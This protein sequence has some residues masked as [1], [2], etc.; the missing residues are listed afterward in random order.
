MFKRGMIIVSL[1]PILLG[2]STLSGLKTDMSHGFSRFTHKPACC[3]PNTTTITYHTPKFTKIKA[4][5]TMNLRVQ[6]HS[7]GTWVRLHGDSRDLCHVRWSVKHN[8]LTIYS[9]QSDQHAPVDVIVNT[10][11]LSS[12]SFDGQ[13][14][15]TAKHLRSKQLDLHIHN[16]GFSTLEG[17]MNLHHVGLSGSGRVEIKSRNN[18]AMSLFLSGRVQTKIVGL[19]N[20][21]RLYMSG[22]SY[23]SLYWIKSQTLE[24]TMTDNARAQMAG[25]ANLAYINMDKNSNLNARYLRATEAFVKTHDAALAKI[26]VVTT[27]HTL[28]KDQSNIYYFNP[29]TYETD[30]MAKNGAVLDLIP[31]DNES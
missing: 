21:K 2:C 17:N 1:L 9:K 25:M 13:G 30:F 31:E 27:Q 14:T 29:A 11:Q 20:L 4:S 12:L 19:T 23:A 8:I 26:A 28:A 24:V 5:G 7:R 22:K 15:L 10:P 6:T 16:K 18:H 3:T